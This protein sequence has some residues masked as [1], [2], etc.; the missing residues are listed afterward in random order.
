MGKKNEGS[1]YIYLGGMSPGHLL[2]CNAGLNVGIFIS[3]T[4]S[5]SLLSFSRQLQETVAV[6]APKC[7]VKFLLSEDGSGKGAALI[8]AV[9]SFKNTQP[10]V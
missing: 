3:H 9:A 6:L 2:L 4:F 7:Q 5:L 10:S 8:A 1:E